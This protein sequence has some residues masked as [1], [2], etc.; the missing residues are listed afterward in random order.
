MS[1]VFKNFVGT[2]DTPDDFIRYRDSNL[3]TYQVYGSSFATA[4]Y[5]PAFIGVSN[6]VKM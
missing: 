4:F 2:L 3:Y 1:N 6:E 5:I